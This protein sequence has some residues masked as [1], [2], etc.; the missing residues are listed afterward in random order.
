MANG[1]DRALL[2]AIA[3]TPI[4]TYVDALFALAVR[5]RASDIHLEPQNDGLCVRL[6][7]DGLLHRIASP[8]SAV[9]D[10]LC[11][12]I[13]VMA[14]MNI[15][16]RRLPQD[17]RISVNSQG[18]MLDLRISTLPTI[19]GEK[20]VL[21]LV[22][23]SGSILQIDQLGLCAA[24]VQDLFAAL[25][26]PQGLILVT[27]PTGS[28][29]TLTLYSALQ[30]LNA[31]HRNIATAEE[32]VE[33]P[34]AGINQVAIKPRIG[35]NFAETL[36]ALLRQ[37]PD[38]L[39]VGEIRDADTAAMAIRAA[40]TGHLIL[41]SVHTKSAHATML[42]LHQLGVSR[43]DLQESVTP[44]MAQRLL[45]RLCPH[46]RQIVDAACV[47]RHPH[48]CYAAN[49]EGCSQC[50]GGYWGRLGIFELAHAEHLST[51][52]VAP[53]DND[54]SRQ[55]QGQSMLRE[56]AIERHLAGETSWQ[57]VN[58]IVPAELSNRPV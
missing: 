57:E 9:A 16:E 37:D 48:T 1:S 44:I 52:L 53:A 56:Q 3:E 32:P 12:R 58:R 26:Q 50:S 17:G 15:A 6:R 8:P 30:W 46:C 11:A 27:G 4:E 5:K 38:V 33:I 7:V 31:Q 47:L 25:C 51:A 42:R 21:R 39:M 40:Q 19:W 29:K 54:V 49:S 41:S 24:Q 43:R 10:K 45:R 14:A 34:L 23:D 2:S 55:V 13:K 20:L 18:H 36:R 22:P 28:G 35:L